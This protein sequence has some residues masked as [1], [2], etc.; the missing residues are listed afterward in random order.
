[1]SPKEEVETN[2]TDPFESFTQI[3]EPEEEPIDILED[4]PL[5]L[6]DYNNESYYLDN[7]HFLERKFDDLPD[8]SHTVNLCI[9]T[10]VRNGCMPYLLYLTVYDK[11]TGTLVFPSTAEVV[12]IVESDTD[13]D[14]QNKIMET[15]KDALFDIY[16]PNEAK[17][18]DMENEEPTD[19]Y[20]PHLFRGFFRH[21]ENNTIL[22]VYDA[23]R[24]NIPVSEDKEYFWASPYEILIL[25]QLRNL[26]IDPTITNMFKTIAVSGGFI[27]HSFYRLRKES[28]KSLVSS[29]YILFPCS[30]TSGGGFNLFGASSSFENI[31]QEEDN[32]INLLVPT[33][34]HPKIG[35]FP[36]FSAM[37]LDPNVPPF[38]RYAVFVDIDDMKPFFVEETNNDVLDNLYGMNQETQYS[39]I[40]F[41]QDNVQYW[42]IKSPLYFTEINDDLQKNIPISTFQEKFGLIETNTPEKNE[43][44]LVLSNE[45]DEIGSNEGYEIGSNEGDKTGSNEG[46]ETGSNEDID[47][48]I[49]Q[50][51][52]DEYKRGYAEGYQEALQ[53]L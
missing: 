36:L 40:C 13:T 37:P 19:L 16:P 48:S 17:P 41:F 23:T 27:D 26:K 2:E 45:G 47:D 52:P 49:Q 20:N 21:K 29:P 25:N 30:R 42:V 6:Y 12:E 1:M 18:M 14:V 46:D 50:D 7:A 3:E 51:E 9:Y 34:D 32:K 22:M 43:G 53:K 33:V 5:I 44:S 4:V 39:S 8:G 28:D 31:R 24:I 35:N 38:K 11:L 15:F 10:C